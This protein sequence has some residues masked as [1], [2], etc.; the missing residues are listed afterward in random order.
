MSQHFDIEKMT[1]DLQQSIAT[2]TLP[3]NM[4]PHML[5]KARSGA[6]TQVAMMRMFFSELNR[7][8]DPQVAMKAM[9]GI[10]VEWLTNAASGYPEDFRPI[11]HE[12]FL[13]TLKGMSESILTG[14][15]IQASA[16]MTI[17]SEKGGHA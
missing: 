10:I 17:T 9:A 6:E 14:T 16:S 2:Q 8:T 11:V 3:Q 5:I 12:D 1:A 4:R 13:N 15:A 7:G